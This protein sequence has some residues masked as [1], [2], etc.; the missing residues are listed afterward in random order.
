MSEIF[1]EDQMIK[2]D[3]IGVFLKGT[4]V[5]F[6]NLN[7]DFVQKAFKMFY[8]QSERCKEMIMCMQHRVMTV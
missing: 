3:V 1:R 6:G 8:K 2:I 7:S 5:L 4:D